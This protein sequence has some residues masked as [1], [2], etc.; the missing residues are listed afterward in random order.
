M[1][2]NVSLF[3]S[4]LVLVLLVGCGAPANQ[5]EGWLIQ[6]GTNLRSVTTS[7][8]SGD[9]L[10]TVEIT[11]TPVAVDQMLTGALGIT[12]YQ[13]DVE[14]PILVRDETIQPSDVADDQVTVSVRV[15]PVT[16]RVQQYSGTGMLNGGVIQVEGTGVFG[17]SADETP[18]AGNVNLELMRKKVNGQWVLEDSSS[19][20]GLQM[21]QVNCG[22]WLQLYRVRFVS[23][24]DNS[25]FM[26]SVYW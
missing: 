20:P 10:I 4:A 13:G 15:E 3:L 25:S 17:I 8:T 18:I 7:V 23:A 26:G 22:T 12:Y 14:V 19:N 2:R 16:P 6:D 5:Y 1:R 9:S 11:A 21:D 24:A